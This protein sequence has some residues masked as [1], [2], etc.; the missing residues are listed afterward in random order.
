M[1]REE[2]LI[3]VDGGTPNKEKDFLRQ[4]RALS[5]EPEEISLVLLTHGHWDHAGSVNAIKRLTGCKIAVNHREKDWV[6]QALKPVPPGIGLS[7]RVF[8]HV[9]TTVTFFVRFAR[10]AV[11]LVLEDTEFSL[12]SYG[13]HG[14]VL[15]T[16]GHSLGSMSLL[17]DTGEAFV[18]DLA[19]TGH[20]VRTRPGLPRYADD[21][22]A[23]P[24]SWRLL[25]DRGAQWIYPA[26]GK[27]F[28]AD[29]LEKLL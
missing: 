8:R 24:G 2:G 10:T 26:H 13:I 12:E 22:D 6:E 11:D 17:L 29:V 1:I 7:S 3:L 25:L 14:K 21:I 9:A 15:H 4:I 27:P 18:G 5:I 16:P 23:V 19:M 28:S 20:P